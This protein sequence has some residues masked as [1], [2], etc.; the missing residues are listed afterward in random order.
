MARAVLRG[1]GGGVDLRIGKGHAWECDGVAAGLAE[2]RAAGLDVFFTGVGWRLGE[3]E[4]VQIV[5]GVPPKDYP[6]KVFCVPEPDAG[7]VSAQLAE[8]AEAGLELWIETHRGG[9]DILTLAGVAARFGV[10]VV[11]DLL[12]L[13]ESGDHIRPALTE[14]APHVRAVQAKGVR[15]TSCGYRHRPLV[16]ADLDVVEVLL[17]AGAPVRAITIETRAGTETADLAVVTKRLGGTHR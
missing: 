17:S 16:D 11:V 13:L 15:K 8:A 7:L 2:F 4:A 9:A 3:P 14:L 12:G 10:G 5:E 6:V 1:G